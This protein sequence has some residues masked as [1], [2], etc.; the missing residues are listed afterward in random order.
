MSGSEGSGKVTKRAKSSIPNETAEE[1][2]DKMLTL[3]LIQA[4]DV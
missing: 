1:K 2:V 3:N 4:T